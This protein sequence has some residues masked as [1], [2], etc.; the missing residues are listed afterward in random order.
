M[1]MERHHL[2][3]DARHSQAN[4]FSVE[5]PQ[6]VRYEENQE[7]GAQP[8]ARTPTGYDRN[9]LHRRLKPTPR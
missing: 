2:T 4:F 3:I 6:H 9:S 7:Y 8:H 5:D 1:S